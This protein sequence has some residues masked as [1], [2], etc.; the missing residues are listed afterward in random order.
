[1]STE[2]VSNTQTIRAI[3]K[4]LE[5]ADFYYDEFIRHIANVPNNGN[6][7][8]YFTFAGLV[9][10][11]CSIMISTYLLT[12]AIN[13]ATDQAIKA[14]DSAR[15][16]ISQQIEQTSNTLNPFFIQFSHFLQSFPNTMRYV[17][18][19]AILFSSSMAV[20]RRYIGNIFL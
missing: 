7:S 18:F 12:R 8:S 11:G 14:T 19:S 9:F 16:T 4:L 10:L 1:M 15:E 13:N 17:F 5:Q 2:S 6:F 3:E 20:F